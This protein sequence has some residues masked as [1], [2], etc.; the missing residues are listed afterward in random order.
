MTK[1]SDIRVRQSEF[2]EGLSSKELA[3]LG[4]MVEVM[5]QGFFTMTKT[6]LHESGLI[7]NLVSNFSLLI[8]L[9]CIS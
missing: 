8:A 2:L 4:V 9:Q 6:A 5:G 1:T 3:S 7:S